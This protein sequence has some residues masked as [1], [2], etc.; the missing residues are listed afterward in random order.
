MSSSGSQG[1]LASPWWGRIS[2]DAPQVPP[3]PHRG[4][5]HRSPL[6]RY[7][8]SFSPERASFRS[9]SRFSLTGSP[10][11]P[12]RRCPSSGWAETSCAS[13]KRSRNAREIGRSVWV[14]CSTLRR[15]RRWRSLLGFRSGP[16]ST[17]SVSWL[18]T[19]LARLLS[20]RISPASATANS[21]FSRCQVCMRDRAQCRCQFCRLK[22]GHQPG[23]VLRSS[24]GWA[25]ILRS[26]RPNDRDGAVWS[27]QFFLSRGSPDSQ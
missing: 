5:L 11:S 6:S 17:V 1:S 8:P 15:F 18:S 19:G 22:G 12:R 14:A 24:P 21:E 20:C 9:I 3:P 23:S 26:N 2:E 25:I 13:N 7:A 27:C 4:R 16:G 10:D